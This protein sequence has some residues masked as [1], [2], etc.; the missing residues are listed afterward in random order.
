METITLTHPDSGANCTFLPERGGLLSSIQLPGGDGLR[1]L[2]FLEKAFN[3][4]PAS[5]PGGWPFCF[6]ICGRLSR[7]GE[8]GV[9]VYAGE[10]Y[11]MDIHG[12]AWQ[13]PWKLV[14]QSPMQLTLQLTSSDTTRAQYPF[15]FVLQLHYQLG[16][17]QLAVAMTL[18]NTGTDRMPYYAGFHPYLAVSSADKASTTLMMPSDYRYRYNAS[19]TDVVARQPALPFP[20]SVA[21]PDINEQL[22]HIAGENCCTLNYSNGDC[23]TM[24]VRGTDACRF[25]FVQLYTREHEPFICVEPWMSHPNAL[26]TVGACRYLAPDEQDHADMSL[27]LK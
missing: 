26:N 5:L 2:L 15:D 8:E 24:T 6:P 10:Q 1:E 7:D 4:D 9:Y 21:D 25:D 14:Q 13:L 23:L 18:K 12:F 20:V 3:D 17:N 16:A 22:N 27:I 11:R 19:L